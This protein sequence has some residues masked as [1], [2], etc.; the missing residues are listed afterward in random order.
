MASSERF[1]PGARCQFLD[2][3]EARAGNLSGLVFEFLERM[4]GNGSRVNFETFREQAP[5]FTRAIGGGDLL[6]LDRQSRRRVRSI[7]L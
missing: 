1:T 5:I 3:D 7:P 4:S 6:W 2:I